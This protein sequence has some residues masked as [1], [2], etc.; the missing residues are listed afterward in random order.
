MY[1]EYKEQVE[2]FE[3]EIQKKLESLPRAIKGKCSEKEL[4]RICFELDILKEAKDYFLYKK[5]KQNDKN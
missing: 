2:F 3:E 5:S 1:E 4:L